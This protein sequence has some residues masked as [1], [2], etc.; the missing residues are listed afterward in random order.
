M[1]SDVAKSARFL[2]LA[3]FLV[4]TL[5]IPFNVVH[6]VKASLGDDQT[7]DSYQV[8]RMP[9]SCAGAPFLCHIAPTL[10]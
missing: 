2:S 10:T 4:T 8:V 5:L 7:L 9:Q 1:S 6:T 3:G